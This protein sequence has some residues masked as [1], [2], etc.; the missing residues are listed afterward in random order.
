MFRSPENVRLPAMYIKVTHGPRQEIDIVANMEMTPLRAHKS[1][2][3]K[4][5][6][7]KWEPSAFISRTTKCSGKT[8]GNRFVT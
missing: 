6:E 1:Y 8:L 7:D 4:S 5:S 3:C 2:T